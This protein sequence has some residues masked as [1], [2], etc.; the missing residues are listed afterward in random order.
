M[1]KDKSLY[2]E[3]KD[4]QHSKKRL[5][6]VLFS[7]GLLGLFLPVLP[8]IALLLLGLSLLFPQQG[9]NAIEKTRRFF[10]L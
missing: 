8:G 7:L 10:K 5:I 4:F 6:P 9:K 3:I 1:L 2:Q